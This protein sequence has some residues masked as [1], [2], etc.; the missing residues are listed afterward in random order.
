M[1]NQSEITNTIT[2]GI[3]IR[4]KVRARLEVLGMNYKEH[5]GFVDSEFVV[6]GT[7][8]QWS[9]IRRYEIQQ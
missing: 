6:T 8:S 1:T 9:Q 3:L 2:V 5:R 7:M 4:H